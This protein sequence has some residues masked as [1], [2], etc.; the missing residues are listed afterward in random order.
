MMQGAIGC[1][2]SSMEFVLDA[3]NLQ[4]HLRQRTQANARKRSSFN[5]PSSVQFELF[6]GNS[7]QWAIFNEALR[8]ALFNACNRHQRRRYLKQEDL[9]IISGGGK[10]TYTGEELRQD[11]GT[12]YLYLIFLAKRISPGN[13][14]EFTPNSLC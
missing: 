11:D 6:Q 7:E 4:G 12:V 5:R 1:A 13:A 8:C 14:V 10:I 3:Q 9:F 2:T